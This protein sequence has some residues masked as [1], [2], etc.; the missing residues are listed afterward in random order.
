MLMIGSG[1][2]SKCSLPSGKSESHNLSFE[3]S[4]TRADLARFE[5]ELER[6]LGHLQ[7]RVR[8]LEDEINRVS[9]Q[10]ARQAQW[11][12]RLREEDGPVDVEEQYRK[13]WTSSGKTPQA[14]SEETTK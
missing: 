8:N 12:D 11:G 5:N 2:T 13:S 3:F 7:T 4:D 6:R 9:H 10:A 1:T 14:G